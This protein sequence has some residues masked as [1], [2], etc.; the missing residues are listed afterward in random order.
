LTEPALIGPDED[1]ASL[2]YAPNE[3]AIAQLTRALGLLAAL[4]GS[5][6][7]DR[8]ELDLQTEL[9]SATM[10]S[11]GWGSPEGERCY[12]RARK[13]CLAVGDERELFPILWGFWLTH[14]IRAEVSEWRQTAAELLAIA[15][16]HGDPAMLVEAHHASWGNPFVGDFATQL[17][18]VERGLSYY[19]PAEHGRLAPQYGGH[20]AGGC[21]LCHR[22]SRAAQGELR[23]G[24]VAGRRDRAPG[25]Q[26]TP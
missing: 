17:A 22:P 10:M 21:G 26:G 23:R 20:D 13:L 2:P 11:Y 5:P 16:R 4:P 7:R 1:A 19:D 8:E 24:V 25:E 3:E 15:E 9:G 12:A 6:E 14:M 18:H